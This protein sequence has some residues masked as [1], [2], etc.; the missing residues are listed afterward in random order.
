MNERYAAL[1]GPLDAVGSV[2]DLVLP[3]PGG[4]IP[5]RAYSPPGA[6]TDVPTVVYLHGGGWVL[7]DLDSHDGVGR[8]L[9]ARSGCLV[10]A[11]HYRLAPEHRFP[12]ALEDAWAALAWLAE[13][14]RDLGGRPDALA[15]CGDSAG[16]ALAAVLARRARDHGLALALQLLAFP[17]ADCDQTR[18]SYAAN[19]AQGPSAGALEW[20]WAHYVGPG[21]DRTHPDASPLRA[22]DLT[23]LC[24]A[25]VITAEYD[26]L[27]DEGEAYADALAAAGVHV[28]RTRY[29]GQIHCFFRLGAVIDRADECL[30]E[31]A[32]VLRAALETASA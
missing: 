13:H 30:A 2:V 3:G 14:A 10:V 27:R 5:V 32:A 31:C 25:H 12:A 6:S 8:A 9:C 21:G 17:I 16:G 19:A 24:P 29:E 22:P 18:P 28:T 26:T 15:V 7:G 20:F 1:F 4:R 11:V 23:R